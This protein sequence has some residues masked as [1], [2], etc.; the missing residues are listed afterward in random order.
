MY[1]RVAAL[2][3]VLNGC[4]FVAMPKRVPRIE[5]PTLPE[6]AFLEVETDVKKVRQGYTEKIE[7]CPKGS[8]SGC[9]DERRQKSRTVAVNTARATVD[10]N[11]ISVG[12]VAMAASDEFRSDTAKLRG[13][14]SSCKRGRMVM[15]VGGLALSSSFFLLNVGFADPPNRGAQIGGIAAVG[16][17][18][19]LMALGRFAF[20]GQ[21]CDEAK[22]LYRK[23]EGV[24]RD[25]DATTVGGDSAELLELLAKKFN[26][27]RARTAPTAD[28]P[29]EHESTEEP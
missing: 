12:A 8:R 27:D 5:Q 13:V 26:R 25:P 1:L 6:D 21:N 16:A 2:S 9:I 4:Y 7:V 23:W 3:V 17:G 24:Y 11:P 28:V 20:G 19:A 10:G 14:T 29:T 15:T 22:S 18:A